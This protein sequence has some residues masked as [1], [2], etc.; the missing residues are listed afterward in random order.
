MTSSDN[1]RQRNLRYV[2]ETREAPQKVARSKNR[3]RVIGHVAGIA[4]VMVPALYFRD[5][6]YSKFVISFLAAIGGT[7]VFWGEVN[8][9]STEQI[10]DL[11]DFID[12]QGIKAEIDRSQI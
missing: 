6:G 8:R 11:H 7:L 2:L 5:V 10:E 3:I 9:S 12:F 1:R 4:L